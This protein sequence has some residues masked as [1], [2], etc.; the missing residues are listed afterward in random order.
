MTFPY[1]FIVIE[2]NISAGKTTLATM[3]AEQ[4]EAKLVLE[5]FADNPFLPLFYRHPERYAFATEIQF[6][7]DRFHQLQRQLDWVQ[8]Q[9]SQLY[10]SD[11]LPFKTLLFAK[12][13]LEPAEY[14]LFEQLYDTL[15]QTLPQPDLIVYLHVEVPRLLLNLKKRNRAFEQDMSAG[16]LKKVESMYLHHLNTYAPHQHKVLRIEAN[17]LDFVQYPHHYEQIVASILQFEP[18]GKQST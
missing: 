14:T 3:L 4:F 11:Y 12:M 10:I 16:Y 18:S 6:M 9:K 7:L 17:A 13:N 8:Q 5:E 1:R 2:G 15:H